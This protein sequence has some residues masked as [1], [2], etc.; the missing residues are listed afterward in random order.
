ME[1]MR[2]HNLEGNVK[3]LED[4]LKS[5]DGIE[6]QFTTMR[7]KIISLQEE[8]DKLSGDTPL[9][10]QFK[11]EMNTRSINMWKRM[12]DLSQRLL[13]TKDAII[14]SAK[15]GIQNFVAKGKSALHRACAAIY[16]AGIKLFENHL[17]M[18]LRTKESSLDVIGRID[19][20]SD[21]SKAV[22]HQRNNLARVLFGREPK[23]GLNSK[24]SMLLNT[25]RK[26]AEYDL[27]QANKRIEQTTELLSRLESQQEHHLTAA[28]Q[29]T[30][31]NDLINSAKN[32][33]DQ[34]QK[35][36]NFKDRGHTS[37]TL[38]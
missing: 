24:D 37:P 17:D 19:E 28:S 31:I 35:T 10:D 7:D 15:E 25:V 22:R 4:L 33:T 26:M 18:D 14:Q 32:R 21:A 34:Q 20:L 11:K 6:A 8:V 23:A 13:D 29:K 38:D 1:L 30:S 27:N 5:L 9:T 36:N 16:G 12:D 3:E 2:K